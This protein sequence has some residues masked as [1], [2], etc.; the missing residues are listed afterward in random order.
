VIQETAVQIGQLVVGV[1]LVLYGL[2]GLYEGWK[3]LPAFKLPSWG[4][5]GDS[6]VHTVVNIS[7][8]LDEA[9]K[10]R[11]ADLAR[12]LVQEMLSPAKKV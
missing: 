9:G 3:R 7:I 4:K 2:Y 12:G 11:A 8:R 5:G 1:G 10:T 6:D